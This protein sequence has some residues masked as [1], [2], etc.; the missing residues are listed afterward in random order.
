MT[1]QKNTSIFDFS[2]YN[3]YIYTKITNSHKIVNKNLKY[4]AVITCIFHCCYAIFNITHVLHINI[5]YQCIMVYGMHE[6]FIVITTISYVY[7]HHC[8]FILFMS[9]NSFYS[10]CLLFYH[11][12]L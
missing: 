2:M 1:S 6:C 12:R 10:Y 4:M 3:A 11:I 7:I 9:D 5:V 8:H